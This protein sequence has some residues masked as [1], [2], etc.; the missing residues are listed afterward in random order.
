MK[1]S[2]YPDGTTYVDVDSSD[3]HTTFKINDYNDLWVLNQFV[4]AM[5]D[6]GYKPTV[7]IPNLI[8]AQADRRFKRGQSTGLK[9]IC[10]FLNGMNAHFKIFHPHNAEVVEAMLDDVEIIDNQRFIQGVLGEIQ[11]NYPDIM[12]DETFSTSLGYHYDTRL[13]DNLVLMSSDAGGFK[14]LV[15]LCDQLN[16]AGQL[17]SCSKGR[18]FDGKKSELTQRIGKEDF[19]GKDIL[20]ID[21]ISVY[22]GTTKGLATLLKQRNCGKIYLAISHMTV[23]NLGNDP[24]TNYFDKV[25]TTNSKFDSYEAGPKGVAANDH[26]ENLKI[27]NLF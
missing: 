20:I 21:D 12:D 1:V 2:K 5:N 26:L 23:Q 8:D 16:W 14:P 24:V 10:N 4:E 27:I 7:T 19:F 18:S 11:K 3:E 13:F 22:G 25:F 15:K 6:I 9:L 17:H